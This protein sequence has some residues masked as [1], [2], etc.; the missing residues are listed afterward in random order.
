MLHVAEDAVIAEF[1][2]LG[3]H[4]GELRGI[5]PTGRTF[6]CRMCALF[7][8]EPGGER[9]VCERIY[10]DQATIAQQLLGD[11]TGAGGG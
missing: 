1:D 4:Q 8:F 3:T 10:F 5:P 11:E 2:L 9:I 7:L 6:R